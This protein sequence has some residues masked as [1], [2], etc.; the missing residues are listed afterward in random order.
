MTHRAFRTPFGEMT[1]F[2]E[3]DAIVALEWGRA[4]GGGSSPLLDRAAVQLREYFAGRRAA[5]DLPLAPVGTPFQRRVWAAIAKIPHGRTATYGE[6]A[7]RLSSG[8]RAVGMACGRNP[9]PIIVPCH[10]VVA[11]DGRLGGYSGGDGAATKRALLRLEGFTP[12]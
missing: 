6:L 8:A 10:R 9:I 7:R 12:D 4:A 5:F 2:E 11:A 1:L 3:K